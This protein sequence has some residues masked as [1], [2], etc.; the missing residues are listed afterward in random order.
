MLI[1][2]CI[3]AGILWAALMLYDVTH[4][5]AWYIWL[6]PFVVCEAVVL[7]CSLISQ[8]VSLLVALAG[9][10]Y[11]V[12]RDILIPLLKWNNKRTDD[13]DKKSDDKNE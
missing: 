12:I 10:L 9:F 7:L 2:A 13:D 8:L 6:L 3:I 1:A 11:L 4:K 5:R